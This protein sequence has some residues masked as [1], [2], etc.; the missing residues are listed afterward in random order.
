MVAQ[1][2]EGA[3]QDLRVVGSNPVSGSYKILLVLLVSAVCRS[4]WRA[5]KKCTSS[6]EWNYVVSNC[7]NLNCVSNNKCC[8]YHCVVL[9]SFG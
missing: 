6:V 3:P 5:M 9:S 7:T 8:K 2:A 4:A 1:M